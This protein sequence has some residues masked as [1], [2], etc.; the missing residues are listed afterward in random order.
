MD[1]K[2]REMLREHLP[3]EFSM[4]FQTALLLSRPLPNE[5][6]ESAVLRNA[7]IDS[8][9]TH[10]RCLLMFFNSP[11][12][13]SYDGEVSARDFVDAQFQFDF[14]ALQR[15]ADKINEQI[16]HLKYEGVWRTATE[17]RLRTKSV[18]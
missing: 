3:Y 18:H 1:E 8:F 11:R 17:R 10:A 4:L 7:L 13:A 12:N 6:G 2:A 15:L 14:R 16:S 9:W 5:N